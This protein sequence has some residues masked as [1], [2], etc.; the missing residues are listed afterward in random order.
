[1]ANT[2]ELERGSL[3]EHTDK[4]LRSYYW[5]RSKIHVR[6]ILT[7]ILPVILSFL[8]TGFVFKNIIPITNGDGGGGSLS[9]CISLGSIFATFGSALISVFS[10]RSSRKLSGFYEKVSI[11]NVEFS[12]HENIQ[13]KRWS[14]L[15]R[16]SRRFNNKK[17]T[18]YF[19]LKNTSICFHI[20][21]NT[22]RIFIPTVEQD[23]GEL[24]IWRNYWILRLKRN[25]YF[26]YI[27]EKN[28]LAEFMI[29]DCLIKLH[30]DILTYKISQ[31]IVLIG[32]AFVLNSI[33][34][35]FF[36]GQLYPLFIFLPYHI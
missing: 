28:C 12:K 18:K 14:F 20:G 8:I 26:T 33:L 17:E 29:W 15:P 5:D 36:Y 16:Q 19:I 3:V 2:Y 13:W 32:G 24:A 7:W 25:S 35:A 1:M 23:F 10:L 22:I 6:N 11:M 34:F 31:I 9:D 4:T 30:E 27:C 21:K